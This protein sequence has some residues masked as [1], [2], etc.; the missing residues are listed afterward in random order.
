MG[1]GRGE[2]DLHEKN[3][4]EEGGALVGHLPDRIVPGRSFPAK[5]EGDFRRDAVYGA[6][7]DPSAESISK[8]STDLG[9]AD[10]NL[11]PQHRKQTNLSGNSA[12]L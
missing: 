6:V 4:S 5:V 11:T 1:D 7:E 3:R 9:R 8:G 2:E 12:R 10:E